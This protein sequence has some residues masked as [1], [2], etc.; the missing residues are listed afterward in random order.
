MTAEFQSWPTPEDYQLN[1]WISANQSSYP[2]Y[3]KASCNMGE[4]DQQWGQQQQKILVSRILLKLLIINKQ[5][6]KNTGNQKMDKSHI[7]KTSRQHEQS[8]SMQKY[9]QPLY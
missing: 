1:S 8:S 2:G 3:E 4:I 5:H 7:H 9:V 6:L